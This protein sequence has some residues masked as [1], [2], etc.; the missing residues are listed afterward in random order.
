MFALMAMLWQFW[1]GNRDLDFLFILCFFNISA[2][3]YCPFREYKLHKP[4]E[5]TY[6]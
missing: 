5:I 4:S 2:L 3:N 6:I 1:F